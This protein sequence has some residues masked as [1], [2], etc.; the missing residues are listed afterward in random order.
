VLPT[1]RVGGRLFDGQ[2]VEVECTVCSSGFS[3]V[4]PY[5]QLLLACNGNA[6]KI[7]ISSVVDLHVEVP[8]FQAVLCRFD[9]CPAHF[10]SKER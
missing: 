6:S 8:S 10:D 1:V 9:L 7:Y 2:G 5:P 4:A 3:V